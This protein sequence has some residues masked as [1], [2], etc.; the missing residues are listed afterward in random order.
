MEL[1]KPTAIGA[2]TFDPNIPVTNGRMEFMIVLLS[3]WL[4]Q[5]KGFNQNYAKRWKLDMLQYTWK[6]IDIIAIQPRTSHRARWIFIKQSKVSNESF[7]VL[8]LCI[9][10]R[11]T[12]YFLDDN[13]QK[14]FTITMNRQIN[15]HLDVN[16]NKLHSLIFRYYDKECNN[17]R[18]LSICYDDSMKLDLQAFLNQSTWSWS[19]NVLKKRS[20][21]VTLYQN[22]ICQENI[23]W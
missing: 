9:S 11:S 12:R 13:W 8:N 3:Y 16:Q 7:S 22:Q 20:I 19:C 1:P 5:D 2:L 23:E 18:R 6:K 15:V 14:D 4:Q 21:E 10:A 17:L